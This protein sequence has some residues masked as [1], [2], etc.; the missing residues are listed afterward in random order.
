[1]LKNYITIAFRNLWKHKLF[2]G[3]NIFGLSLSMSV[4]LV[5]IL[6]VYDHFQYD[7][8]HPHADRI[9]RI[10]TDAKGHEGPFDEKYASSPLPFKNE[11]VERYSYI[12]GGS[13]LNSYFRGEIRSP[14]KILN[15]QSLYAD[16]AF[17]DVFAFELKEGN[18]NALL[19]P[20][21]IVL[22]EELSEK[23]FP[24]QSALGQTIE[25]EDHGSYK[26]TGVVKRPPG[27]THLQFEALGSLNTLP[28]LAEKDL[29]SDSYNSWKE[30]WSGYNYLVLSDPSFKNEAEDAINKLAAEKI[31][32]EEDEQEMVFRLQSMNDIVPGGLTSNE[33][34][35]TLPWFVLVFFGL[36][37]FIVLVT[38]SINYTNLSIA[39]ALSRAKEIAIRKVNGASK[40]QIISQFLT[41][42]VITAFIS[43]LLAVLIYRFLIISFNEI[44]IFSMIGI[45]LEDSIGTYGYFILFT[46]ILGLFTGIGPAIF[47][48]KIK[49]VNSLKGSISIVRSRKRSIFKHLTGKR[50]LISV[51]FSLSIIM[52]VTILI[53]NKQGEFLVNSNYG[54]NESE[55]FYINTHKQNPSTIKQHF[56]SISGVENVTFTSH[57]PA[58]G[59]SHGGG[60]QWKKDQE[61]ITLYYFSVD[62]NYVDVMELELIAG[63]NFPKDI[64]AQNEKFLIINQTAVET[65][66]FESASQAIGETMTLDTLGLQIIGVVKDYHW[67]PLMKSIRPLALRIMPDRYEYAYLKVRS[68]DMIA[69]NKK[70]EEAWTSFDATREYEGGFLNEQLDEFYQFF[71]DLGNILAYVAMIALSITG[72]GFLGMVSFELKTKVKEIGIRKVLGASFRS[73]TLSMGKGFLVMITITSVIAIPF[74]MWVNGLWV[75]EMASHAPVDY[76]IFIPTLIIVGTIALTTI[77]SQVWI[78]A[79]KNPTET[80]RAE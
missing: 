14:H 12:Q 10:T 17:F 50:T 27:K 55:V 19:E 74:A 2:T 11:L 40:K 9:Y 60:A 25:F 54:F 7:K 39:K 67:E 29:V 78:N 56:E 70:F 20:F 21:S 44:W 66:G 73:L 18:K 76:T 51:Q 45:S 65:Y 47:L 58:V 59:R 30:H 1:M 57:H 63:R 64:S 69:Q 5:L 6:L 32:Y 68:E 36:L 75:N 61:P 37:G 34:A 3:L 24:D 13:N 72:L 41:E 52:L 49:A 22:S 23:L 8:F 71:Y 79:N 26:V 38:A 15:I 35:F 33:I 16:E 48:S 80:L 46:L 31:E 53:L 77:L 28:V 62:P 42:S 4:C 43:L